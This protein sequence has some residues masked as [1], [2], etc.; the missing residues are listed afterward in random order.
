MFNIDWYGMLKIEYDN[1]W[2]PYENL[3]LFVGWNELSKYQ[4]LI[5]QHPNLATH[6]EF[7]LYNIQH[8]R[9]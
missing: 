3:K 4:Y 2:M 8:Q 9:A 7:R 1:G 5:Y 6:D